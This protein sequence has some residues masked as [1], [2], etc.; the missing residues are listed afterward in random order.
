MSSDGQN[1]ICISGDCTSCKGSINGYLQTEPELGQPAK[2]SFIIENADPKKHTGNERRRL[3]GLAAQRL[4][5]SS[6]TPSSLQNRLANENSE[7]FQHSV[8]NVTAN[9]I[10]CG[11]YRIKKNNKLAEHPIVALE[12]LKYCPDFSQT[13]SSIGFNP[14]FVHYASPEQFV[15][16]NEYKKKSR[17]TRIACD[18]T[19]NIVHKIG[20]NI[21]L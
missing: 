9:A 16:Y 1:Y 13:I 10:S 17:R 18:A 11:R 6:L 15:M 14:F 4:Y 20:K 21:N 7:L 5:A 12:Y 3:N 8:L 19:G 2:F